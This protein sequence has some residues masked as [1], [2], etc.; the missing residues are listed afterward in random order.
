[1]WPTPKKHCRNATENKS[2]NAW[3]LSWNALPLFIINGRPLLIDDLTVPLTF[4]VT[5]SSAKP[6]N[7]A[8]GCA[9][10]FVPCQVVKG[11]RQFP[12]QNYYQGKASAT[13]SEGTKGMKA[14]TKALNARWIFA[15]FISTGSHR[16]S[17]ELIETQNPVAAKGR[18]TTPLSGL[19]V[20]TICPA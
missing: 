2:C 20:A 12:S 19:Y 8:S 4:H 7:R 16:I 10:F 1:M 11:F 6:A 17:F 13:D 14:R 9:G 15:H 3:L 18:E 5:R